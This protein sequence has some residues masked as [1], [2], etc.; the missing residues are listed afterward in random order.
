MEVIDF[1]A[2]LGVYIWSF[3]AGKK[4]NKKETDWDEFNKGMDE[5]MKK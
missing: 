1:F 5:L 4:T 3:I 2:N